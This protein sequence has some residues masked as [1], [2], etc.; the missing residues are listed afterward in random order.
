[1]SPHTILHTAHHP[2]R[3]AMYSMIFCSPLKT[4]AGAL[5]LMILISA[6]T[7][8]AGSPGTVRF[9]ESV[10][11][12]TSL[13][14]P[15]LPEAA[16]V[17]PSAIAAAR[18][19]IQVAS[20]YYS[21]IGDGNDASAPAGTPDR[22]LPTLDAL[23]AAAAR[24]V[25]VQILAD[26]KFLKT[27]PE[28]PALFAET[29]GA[30][31]RI[32]D[33]AAMWDGVLHAK[34]MLLDDDSFYVGSQ[35]WDWRAMDQIHELGVLV[36]QPEMAR[37]VR[38]VYEMDWHLAAHP[39]QAQDT[40]ADTQAGLFDLPGAPVQTTGGNLVQG[41]VAASPRRALP[42]G[43]AWDLP[44]LVDLIDSARDSVHLQLL[45]YGV[46][47]REGR[48]FE[49]LDSALRRAAARKVDVRIILSNWSKSK[50]K[51]PWIKSLAVLP[52]LEVRFTN[53]PE[54][55][56]GFI[57]FARVEHAK[58]LTVDGKGLWIGTSN[59][60]RD[61]FYG[62]RNLSLFFLGDGAST[63]PDR[64]FNQSWHSEYAETVTAAGQYAPP[65]R[66]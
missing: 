61:Y 1:M 47:D 54:Y 50:Y 48:L 14:L 19:T 41:I 34:Y 29:E 64:F 58:Y 43:I 45:S 7:A 9:V 42:D 35:N 36:Q 59:W 39:D 6:C 56:K 37:Q 18:H 22:L 38:S 21:R 13:D 11:A 30:E 53:I 3:K 51:L 40:S 27:Y 16:E 33:A 23:T 57:P 24:G 25:K 49:D 46:T 65:R 15:D 52:N 17:W 60:S 31:T 12:E 5:S 66:N 26:S 8:C 44:L 20:F 10:P 28:V 2:S 32:L 62:S 4:V 55:S 63:E